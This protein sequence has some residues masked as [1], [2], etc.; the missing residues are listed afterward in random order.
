MTFNWKF[1]AHLAGKY[2]GW[3]I[4]G[5]ST[6]YECQNTGALKEVIGNGGTYYYPSKCNKKEFKSEDELKNFLISKKR[7]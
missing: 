6:I 4:T 1:S 7:A 5:G 2:V 3:G